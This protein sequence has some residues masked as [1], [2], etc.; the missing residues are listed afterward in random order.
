MNT[1]A[2]YSDLRGQTILITG[3][4]QGIGA[5]LVTAFAE[6]QARVVFLDKAK[7][8]GEELQKRLRA[9]KYDVA[10]YAVDL[11]DETKLVSTLQNVLVSHG[12][13][14]ALITNA[15]FDPRFTITDMTT[16]SWESLF[17]LNVGHAFITSRTCLPAMI[18]AQRGSIIMTSSANIWLGGDRL[19]CYTATKAALMGFVRSLAAEV[20]RHHIRVNS[21]APGWV[22]TERQMQDVATEADRTW[23][24]EKGQLLPFLLQPADMAPT[25][26]F[27][28]SDASRAITRQTILVDAGLTKG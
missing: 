7:E 5:A 28:A 20:G 19:A 16:D 6:Q 27:L 3:G 10:F 1:S 25:F 17:K 4:A 11:T 18:A 24:V 23:L 21:V 22:M 9:N 13:P 14:Y 2:S 8:P 12:A 26:L 15:G